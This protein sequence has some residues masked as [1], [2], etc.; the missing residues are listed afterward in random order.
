[1]LEGNQLAQKRLWADGE[2]LKDET[3]ALSEKL[4]KV[5]QLL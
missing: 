3:K 4:I 5:S 2:A 1:M